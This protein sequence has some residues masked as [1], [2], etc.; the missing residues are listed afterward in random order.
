MRSESATALAELDERVRTAVTA[1]VAL[2]QKR[3]PASTA[4]LSISYDTIG[5]R[6]TGAQSD[7]ARIVQV[8]LAAGRACLAP[9][10]S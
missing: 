8:A 10:P 5:I 4:R 3:W 6:P 1:A 7:D 9:T 2:E